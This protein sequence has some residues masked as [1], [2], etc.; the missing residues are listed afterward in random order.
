MSYHSDGAWK[1]DFDRNQGFVG[2]FYSGA[3]A[4]ME[5]SL[6]VAYNFQRVSQKFALPGGMK[7]KLL[8]NTAKE[9]AVLREPEYLT[10]IRE[11]Q[12]ER[13][14]VCLLSGTESAEEILPEQELSV[15]QSGREKTK[16]KTK[17]QGK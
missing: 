10:D 3:Y 16:I 6:Y 8:L 5:E 13:Q 9:P 7:W 2:M 17:G 4:G 12:V 1:M 11:I 14:S 15:K